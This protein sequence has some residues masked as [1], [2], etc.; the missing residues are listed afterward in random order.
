[1]K[2]STNNTERQL[3][4]YKNFSSEKGLSSMLEAIVT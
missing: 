3:K 4:E 2:T 1:M